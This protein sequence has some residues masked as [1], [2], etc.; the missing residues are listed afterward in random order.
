MEAGQEDVLWMR[1]VAI[2]MVGFWI[3]FKGQTKRVCGN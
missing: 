2:E 3:D 1:M